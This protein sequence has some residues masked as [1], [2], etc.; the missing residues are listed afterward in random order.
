M[1][2]VVDAPIALDFGVVAPLVLD[3]DVVDGVVAPLVLDFDVVDGVVA[4]LV[5]DF[6]VVD[7]VVAPLVLDFDVVDQC[8]LLFLLGGLAELLGGDGHFGVGLNVWMVRLAA[9]QW[10]LAEL[11][12]L[13]L[14]LVVRAQHVEPVL[15]PDSVVQ[16]AAIVH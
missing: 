16:I 13:L 10:V 7:G 14:L 6:D 5:L 8:R 12:L 2:D 11:L 15:A 3:F 9:E 1:V 4:P